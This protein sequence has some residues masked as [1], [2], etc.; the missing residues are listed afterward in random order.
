MGKKNKKNKSVLKQMKKAKKKAKKQAKKQAR[1]AAEACEDAVEAVEDAV[2]DV[3]DAAEDVAKAVAAAAERSMAELQAMAKRAFKKILEAAANAMVAAA[4]D[5][6]TWARDDLKIPVPGQ[7]QF[8][9]AAEMVSGVPFVGGSMASAM[10]EKVEEVAQAFLDA[11]IAVATDPGCIQAFLDPILSIDLDDAMA[12]CEK[13]LD[14]PALAEFFE[15]KCG[16]VVK[17]TMTGVV[18]GALEACALT[19]AF[20]SAKEAYNAIAGKVPGLDEIDLDLPTYVLDNFVE[21]CKKLLCEKEYDAKAGAKDS[22]DDDLM[23]LFG[24]FLDPDSSDSSDSE[25]D[26]GDDATADAG[27]EGGATKVLTDLGASVTTMAE[28]MFATVGAPEEPE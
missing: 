22:G 20:P 8:D 23:E 14:G 24:D 6:G 7:A 26:A 3:V 13:G 2:E 19:A 27:G 16:A 12:L 1:K 4:Q 28:G 15:E 25:S 10:T 11:L 9:A 5:V 17:E 18:E 21:G